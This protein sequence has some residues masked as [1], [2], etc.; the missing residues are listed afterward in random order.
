MEKQKFEL[1]KAIVNLWRNALL[2][3]K[4]AASEARDLSQSQ[5]CSQHVKGSRYGLKLWLQHLPVV[6]LC[7]HVS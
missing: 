3:T 6:L 7:I 2:E 4:S 5:Q 1:F